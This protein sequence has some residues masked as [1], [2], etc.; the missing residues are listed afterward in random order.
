MGIDANDIVRRG[1]KVWMSITADG[2]DAPH[3]ERSG[4]A[5]TRPAAGG[6]IGWV[7]GAPRFIADAVADP[8]AGL[9]AAA[10][11]VQLSDSPGRWLVDVARLESRLQHGVS[12]VFRRAVLA[13]PT[14]REPAPDGGRP[15]ALGGDTAAVLTE[16]GIEPASGF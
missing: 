7:D 4:S 12:S 2:R 15:L 3:R 14:G 6:L 5:T 11:V 1:P 13:V 10:A 9:T 16:F 8:L